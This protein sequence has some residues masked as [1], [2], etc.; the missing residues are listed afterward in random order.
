M[1]L[2]RDAA[3]A[4]AGLNRALERARRVVVCV[5]QD[6]I[7]P[8]GVT[9]GSSSNTGWPSE[10]FGPIGVAG[11]YGVG[12][13]IQARRGPPAVAERIGRV[14]DRDGC[15][16][17]GRNCPRGSPRSTSCSSSYPR[18]TPLRFDPE[19]GFHLYGADLCLQAR[20]RGLAV[21]ALGGPVPAQL[22]EPR[23]PESFFAS[24]RVFA[25]KW[26]V[27]CRWRR[28]ALFDER[29]G[30]SCWGMPSPGIGIAGRGRVIGEALER[31]GRPP[32]HGRIARPSGPVRIARRRG[33]D[34][35]HRPLLEP[36]RIHPAVRPA[37]FR[38]T[39][40][41]WELIVV[42]NGSTDGTGRVPRRRP[43][44]R[45]GA[46]HGHHATR[47]TWGS[48]RPINQGLQAARGEFLVLLNNDA[49]VTDGWLDQLIA[50]TGSSR[51]HRGDRKRRG[52]RTRTSREAEGRSPDRE[53]PEAESV[54]V[55]IGL[56]GPMSNYAAPPQWVEDVPY[57]DLDEM[58]VFARRWRDE[59]RGQWFTA[60][61]LSGFCMLMT[62][63][64]YEAIGGLD[65]R[66]GLGFFDDDDL[67]ERAR[68]AGFELAVAQ[69]LF[70]HHFG[71]RTFAGNGVDAE[72]LLEENERRFAEKWGQDVPARAAGRRCGPGPIRRIPDAQSPRCRTPGRNDRA[73]SGP[74]R[75]P[76][77]DGR[78]RRTGPS[79][80]DDDRPGRGEEP[81]ALP[82][83][84]AGD[85]R[86]DRRRRHRQRRPH[87]RD[88]PRVRGPGVRFR[89]GRRLRRGAERGAGAGHR[90]LCLL[91]RCRRRGRA[92]GAGE[93]R[94]LLR[95]PRP[96]RPAS[97]SLPGYVVRA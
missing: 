37:L 27:G 33:L 39:R 12:D 53:S 59:H 78:Q 84:G 71:S 30:C 85:L 76:V 4:A 6:V 11:V 24:A 38:H 46:G 8:G 49:V 68:R 89:L 60:G 23:L 69:D 57:R 26:A 1:I 31:R 2:V 79:Q 13:V 74:G 14:V 42:D 73:R 94:A 25:R 5:H 15:S 35:D 7:C 64:V 87:A 20:E 28:L 81:A 41:P 55:G 96:P 65:E 19:L 45:A 93:A 80:P 51:C 92:A 88:R 50:L 95:W 66:F 75:T 91:A 44:R 82:G 97:E 70:V 83:V 86:R 36:A 47:R 48:R 22:A 34:L 40:R 32:R 63:A 16:M 29:G 54:A 67:A 9:G 62:R 52:R 18:D 21:V 90:R 77:L 58:H 43:G 61:K 10:R 72:A 56:V 3:S 17:T